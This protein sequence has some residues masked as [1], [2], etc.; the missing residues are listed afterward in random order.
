MEKLGLGT[1][2]T[3]HDIIQKLYDRKYAVGN[4]LIPTQSGIA[5]ASALE[6]H[7]KIVTES[8]MTAHL[9]QDMEDIANGKTTLPE[10]VEES[11]DMLSDIL[12]VM[13]KNKQNIGD[14]IRQALHEQSFIGLC[15]A[16][17]GNLRVLR[18][19]KGAEFIGCSGYPECKKAF[20][21]PRGAL[22]QTTDQLCDLCK[23]P[24]VRVIR[25][26]S[27]P[28]V[29]CIDPECETNRDS[30]TVGQCPLCGKDLRI[31]YSR[32]GKQFIGCS[33]YPECKRTYPLPQLGTVYSTGNKCEVCGAP[34]MGV[35]GPRSWQFCADMDCTSNKRAKKEKEGEEPKKT[36]AKKPVKKAAAKKAPAKKA[37]DQGDEAPAKTT[38]AKKPVK[39]APAKKKVKPEEKTE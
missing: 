7:A 27:P 15:P 33:G 12:E 3:R 30:T 35:K 31:L 23:L 2:S 11:Q 14:E 29:I 19:R 21:K 8:K 9:E 20:P 6:R 1:K 38:A 5:V 17:G 25:R 36:A 39:K 34:V 13:D 10:V 18:S 16:C 37:A 26:G 22:V 4:D 32:F 24:K 28:A